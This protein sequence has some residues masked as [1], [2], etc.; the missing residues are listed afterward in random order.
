MSKR[1]F[2]TVIICGVILSL[3]ACNDQ[4]AVPTNTS[5]TSK[6]AVLPDTSG[7]SAATPEGLAM[8]TAPE[9]TGT[10]TTAPITDNTAR[11]TSK[12]TAPPASS[13]TRPVSSQTPS[14]TKPPVA[15]TPQPPTS[16]PAPTAPKSDFEKPYNLDKIY[17]FAKQYGE[18]HG[19]IWG[20][21]LTKDNCSWE[22]PGHT[23]SFPTEAKMKSV[24]TSG[25]DR[26]KSIQEKNGY[27]LGQFY[28]KLYFEPIDNGEY[29]MYWLIG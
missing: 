16:T 11:T 28:F 19:M 5:V 3:A 15:S 14:T 24:I 22:A 21:S 6:N 27:Q 26:V 10:Q 13:T 2:L 8:P 12:P 1:L 29:L 25:I 20:D 7:T 18:D 9:S 17:A 4:T 23:S